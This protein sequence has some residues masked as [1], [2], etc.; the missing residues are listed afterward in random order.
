ML[1]S[2]NREEAGLKRQRRHLQQQDQILESPKKKALTVPYFDSLYTCL[3]Q[4]EKRG[5]GLVKKDG[6]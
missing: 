4:S 5:S 3:N 1:A 2:Q 6:W